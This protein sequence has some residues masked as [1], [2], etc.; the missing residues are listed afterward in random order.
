MALT[1]AVTHASR[2]LPRRRHRRAPA[3]STRLAPPL[4]TP[5]PPPTRPAT[6]DR[7]F[8]DLEA[9]PRLLTPSL[10]A[11][12]LAALPL[13]PSPRRRLAALRGLLPVSL[14]RRHPDLALR[15]LHIHASLGLLAYAHHIFDHLLPARTRRD[16]AFPWNCLVAGYAHVGRYD[17][18]LALYLQMDEE[19]AP[20]DG[21]T[22]ESALRAC[23]GA[24][25]AELGR[26][27]HRDAVSAGLAADVS[28]CD[29]LVEMYAQCGDLEMACQVFDAMPER[30]AVSW[31]VMLAG[32][33][34]HGGLSP[35]AT[36]VWRRM[37][38]EGHKPDSVVLSK[39]LCH[40]PDD[41]KQG[42]EVHAWVIRHELEIELPVANALIGM[43]ARKKQLGHAL[44]I[45]ESMPARDLASWN[46]IISAHSQH[47]GVLMMFCR[48]VDSGLQPNEATFVA[49]L[50]A[51][52]NLGLVEGG[53]RLFSEMENKYRIQHTV[54]H[55]TSVVNMLG[56]A[57]M[58]DEAYEFMS[59]R[60]RLGSEPTVLRAL[61]HA[62]SVHGNIRI[63]EIAAKKLF[64]LE[65]DNAHHFVTLMKMYDNTGRLEEL[66]KVKKTMRDKGL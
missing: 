16:R 1:A 39:M 64:D 15:L 45:F 36:E 49:V 30:D 44:S 48:M 19:G 56:K 55:C 28:V 46:A 35:Q 47:F 42:L 34:G 31:N 11:P 2:A 58:V 14:L 60:P 17:D 10:L 63:G 24:R 62:S 43:Y 33:L 59:K 8:S 26:A 32:L 61:L 18:A 3:P 29:A 51:C 4:S 6:L 41:G 38:G 40:H 57:G 54:Q 52:D 22:F 65:P 53:M 5:T 37:L 21:F 50:S 13:H 66:E 23:A 7:V 12:L 25:S 27:V 9:Q 20:R